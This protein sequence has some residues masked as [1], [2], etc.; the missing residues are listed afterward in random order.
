MLGLPRDADEAAIKAKYN[1]LARRW[2]PDK[3]QGDDKED[4][5]NKFIEIQKAYTLLTKRISI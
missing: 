2:H 1:E 4:A 5:T 3:Y